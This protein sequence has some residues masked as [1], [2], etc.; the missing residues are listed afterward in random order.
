MYILQKEV[1]FVKFA[2]VKDSFEGKGRVF[3]VIRYV[4][5]DENKKIVKKGT[6]IIWLTQEEFDKISL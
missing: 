4:I 6:P 1:F 2:L 3:Y 5:I